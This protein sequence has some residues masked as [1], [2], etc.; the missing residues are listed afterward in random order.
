MVERTADGR[1]RT[2]EWEDIQYK[3]GNRV[4][5]YRDREI[6]IVAQKLADGQIDSQLRTY[7]PLTE[8]VAEKVRR[9]GYG[10]PDDDDEDQ[11]AD[12]DDDHVRA[13]KALRA[14]QGGA[15]EDD[16]D[17]ALEAF[18]ARRIEQ[19]QQQRQQQSFKFGRVLRISGSQ[20]V[21][22]ITNAS[23][24]GGPN[25][26][27]CWVVAVMIQD[28]VEAC[29]A[30]LQVLADV[31]AKHNTVKFVALPANEAIATFP[32][33][34]LPC[35]LV[36]REGKVVQQT[37]G[38]DVWGGMKRLSRESCEKALSSM[39]VVPRIAGS[40]DD[41]DDDDDPRQVRSGKSLRRGLI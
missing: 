14:G 33:K 41:E 34:H 18:R 24:E 36:Y 8:K 9:G 12:F 4:G 26:G 21:E 28:G 13:E 30:L 38:I 32:A 3:H 5:Q 1:I 7:D 16:D 15:D 19:I 25:G 31:S 23:A 27:P 17:D 37:T 2:T 39:G 22:E 6:D 35:V 10:N 40:D 11:D 20:Y 29:D